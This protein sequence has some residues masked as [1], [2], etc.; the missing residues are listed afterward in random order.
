MGKL[1]KTERL[2]HDGCDQQQLAA[3]F[4]EEFQIGGNDN[5]GQGGVSSAQPPN[6][7]CAANSGHSI[8]G[9]KQIV[10]AGLERDPGLLSVRR[11]GDLIA[12]L[13]KKL[14]KANAETGLVLGIQDAEPT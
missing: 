3:G 2:G 10:G 6:Q 13:M 1:P 5:D 12:S 4:S 7:F 9:N 14:R 11:G 8:V